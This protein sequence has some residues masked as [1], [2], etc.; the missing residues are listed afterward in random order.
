MSK[1][2]KAK[3]VKE[4]NEFENFVDGILNDALVTTNL[5]GYINMW[6]PGAIKIFG[7]SSAEAVGKNIKLFSCLE[8]ENMEKLSEKMFEAKSS[9]K[10]FG[11][12]YWKSVSDSFK[13]ETYI[14]PIYKDFLFVGYSFVISRHIEKIF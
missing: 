6:Y 2:L 7:Y 5:Q 10:Y 12:I 9:G 11:E 14:Q 3:T 4:D 8:S 13:S 1:Y